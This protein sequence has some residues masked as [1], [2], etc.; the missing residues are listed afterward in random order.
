MIQQTAAPLELDE[1]IEI[2]VGP[3]LPRATLHDADVASP[4]AGGSPQHLAAL[5]IQPLANAH[6]AIIG[7]Q[8]EVRSLIESRTASSSE[9]AG[10]TSPWR[11][12]SSSSG[13][14]SECNRRRRA[15]SLG[16]KK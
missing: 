6:A 2:A 1:Q 5:L 12:Y 4:V 14:S 9:A 16:A 7:A 11:R 8:A 15:A 3:R 10:P 13:T